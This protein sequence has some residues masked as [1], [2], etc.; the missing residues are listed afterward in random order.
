M[1]WCSPNAHDNEPLCGTNPPEPIDNPDAAPLAKF[2]K[3]ARPT[4]V[5]RALAT[6]TVPTDGRGESLAPAR[7][8]A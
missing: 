4:G 5:G 8:P 2:E 7:R 6:Y 3:V 1:L